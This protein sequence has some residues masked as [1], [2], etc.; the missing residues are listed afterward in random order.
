MSGKKYADAELRKKMFNPQQS[1]H[2]NDMHLAT[3][4]PG[5][6]GGGGGGGGVFVGSYQADRELIAP[7]RSIYLS[8]MLENEI[9]SI[10]AQ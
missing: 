5:D 2:N 8:S 4:N 10:H 1:G 9:I 3:K 7:C 6:W